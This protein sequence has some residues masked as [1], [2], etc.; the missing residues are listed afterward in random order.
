[1]KQVALDGSAAL[2]LREGEAVD[3]LAFEG[4]VRIEVF[5]RGVDVAMAHQL[6]DAYCVPGC[7]CAAADSFLPLALV[8]LPWGDPAPHAG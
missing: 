1:L 5:S 2:F 8:N 3:G 4:F 7:T 6:L